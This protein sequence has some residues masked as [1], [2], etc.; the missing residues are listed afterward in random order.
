[1]PDKFYGKNTQMNVFLGL[2]RRYFLGFNWFFHWYLF[3]RIGKTNHLPKKQGE[4]IG[5]LGVG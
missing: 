4:M 5:V 1:M 3:K 2:Y